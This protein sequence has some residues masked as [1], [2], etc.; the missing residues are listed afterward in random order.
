V[1]AS[2]ALPPED[3]THLF[4]RLR[5]A[6]ADRP[7][8]LVVYDL[9]HRGTPKGMPA[10]LRLGANAYVPDPTRHDTLKEK[11]AALLH[12]AGTKHGAGGGEAEGAL[13]GGSR[14][15]AGGE[16]GPGVVAETLLRVHRDAFSGTLHLDPAGGDGHVLRFEAGVVVGVS[17]RDPSATLLKWLVAGGRI[18]EATRQAALELTARDGLSQ[19]GA[20]VSLGILDPGPELL[21]VIA[22]HAEHLVGRWFALREGTYRL[23]EGAAAEGTGPPIS[24][25][26]PPLVRRASEA[27]DPASVWQGALSEH[28]DAYPSRADAFRERFDAMALDPKEV[29]FAMKISGVSTTREILA[30]SPGELKRAQRLLW[31]F[32]RL[33]VIEFSQ[34]PRQST[35][36]GVYQATA[37][38]LTRKKKPL[39]E[40]EAERL[41]EEALRIV[42]ASYFGVLGVDI[43]ADVD[44]VERAYHD[45]A[46]RFH[47]ESFAEYDVEDLEDLLQTVLDRAGAAYRVLSVEE[48]RKAYLAHLLSRY[49]TPKRRGAIV[50]EAEILLRRGFRRLDGGDALG[51]AQMFEEAARLDPKEPAYLAHQAFAAFQ[52]ARGTAEDRAREPRKILKK[53][54]SL[55][56]EHEQALLVLTLL[57]DA[58][59]HRDVARAHVLGV[60]RRSP[61]SIAAKALLAHVNRT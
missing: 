28:L 40:A 60:L 2:V 44:D 24:L 34:S 25:A 58:C 4:E 16:L 20:L 23:V 9:G 45:V 61:R 27:H 29:A 36:A 53:A 37:I 18:D 41:R 12:G 26:L 17:S 21:E 48:K 3:G 42:T 47:P 43:A 54:L 52:A 46:M 8:P 7:V 56:P 39:P 14:K 19:T 15:V 32:H 1:I 6:G 33:G 11:V 5:A 22:G 55:D 38:P 57:E 10:V 59:G 30:A 51:A 49:S 35:D 13:G 50:P 31:F